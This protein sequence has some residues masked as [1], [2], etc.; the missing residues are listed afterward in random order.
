MLRAVLMAHPEQA[1]SLQGS[2]SVG[3]ADLAANDLGIVS[4]WQ[5][6]MCRTGA[7]PFICNLIRS[8]QIDKYSIPSLVN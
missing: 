3:C 2:Y 7:P 5:Q 4:G 8:L 6:S 1:S